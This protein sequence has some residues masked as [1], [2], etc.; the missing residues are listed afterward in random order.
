MLRAAETTQRT[1]T[2]RQRRGNEDSALAR[3]PV[4]VV[5]DGM[6]GAQAGEVASQLAVEAFEAGLPEEGS[7]EERL[8]TVV[9]T[10]NRRIHEL[11]LAEHEH[12]GMGTTLTAAYLDEGHV[13]IAHVGDSRAYLFRDGQLTRLTQDHSLVEELRQRGKLTEEEAAEHPQRSI[14]TRALG[15]EPDVQVDTFSQAVRRGD[16]VLLCSDGLTSMISEQQIS[17]ILDAAP[18]LRAA[19]DR[20]IDS[21]NAA[22]GK[23]N[24]TVVLFRV[25]E[26]GDGALDQP[27]MVGAM[28]SR[29][30]ATRGSVSQDAAPAARRGDTGPAPTARPPAARTRTV[31]SE[32]PARARRAPRMARTQGFTRASGRERERH[33]GRLGKAVAA[34]IAVVAVIFLIGGGGYLASRQLY[35]LGTNGQGIVTVYRGFPYVLPFGVPMYETFYV[36]GVPASTIPRDRRN[37][38]LDHDLRS[39]RSATNLINSIERGG[40]SG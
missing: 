4:F 10:A 6:G 3:A 29:G 33:F 36:S 20:L 34:V 18:T 2:G 32:A 39:Q 17:E 8:A 38:L 37:T 12:R 27:T 21:A 35:F 25:E 5:A 15:P 16:V 31:D 19:G 7:P 11:S 13:A 22:G 30:E 9:H 1:D 23:D 28:A 24:I 26:A 40:I 14:I